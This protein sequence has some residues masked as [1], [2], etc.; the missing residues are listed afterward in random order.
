ML[1][2]ILIIDPEDEGRMLLRNFSIILKKLHL[3]TKYRTKILI[4]KICCTRVS[5]IYL[6]EK[7]IFK[8]KGKLSYAL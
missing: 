5:K 2:F 6:G 1:P 8:K 3:F 7:V 4:W